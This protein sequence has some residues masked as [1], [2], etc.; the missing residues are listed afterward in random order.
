MLARTAAA[1]PSQCSGFVHRGRPRFDRTLDVTPRPAFPRPRK[2]TTH[3]SRGSVEIT[4]RELPGHRRHCTVARKD[5]TGW[6]D[7]APESSFAAIVPRPGEGSFAACLLYIFFESMGKSTGQTIRPAPLV[8][9]KLER[10]TN[11]ERCEPC[12]CIYAQ[13]SASINTHGVS[14]LF[15]GVCEAAKNPITAR[16]AAEFRMAPGRSCER[17]KQCPGSLIAG[18]S[19]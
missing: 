15:F 17:T 7:L 6:R 3:A 11:A 19:P 5:L 13:K 8:G 9:R 1:A 16:P 14:G 2:N 12:T 10:S 18:G 4:S